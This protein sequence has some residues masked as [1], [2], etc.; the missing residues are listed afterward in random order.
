MRVVEKLYFTVQRI[1]L[2]SL[3][4]QSSPRRGCLRWWEKIGQTLY[5]FCTAKS[6][7]TLLA[8][9]DTERN[10]PLTPRGVPYASHRM[11]WWRCAQGHSWR[12]RIASRTQGAADCPYCK[13]KRVVPGETDLASC[14]PEVAAQWDA[15][16]NGELMP[17][18]LLPS[19]NRVVWWLCEK[20][21]S[22]RAT[23]AHRTREGSACPYCAG[24]RVLPGFNDLAALFP[25]V[26]GQWHPT[27]N[28]ALTP[29]EVTAR[30]HRLIW[31][32]CGE[33]HVW[34]AKIYSRTDVR[35]CG[36]PICA[37]Q[38]RSKLVTQ[39]RGNG[40]Q[41]NLSGGKYK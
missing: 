38:A 30:S 1:L 18:S 11:A 14:F 24:R 26:A 19:S 3:L 9:W 41:Y 7:S 10:A 16:R 28:G 27:L 36:C 20:N 34:K 2:R 37:R 25:K 35:Q 5:D 4:R 23:V 6:M 29:T 12:A 8:Q 21:H 32:Q 17:Q 39:V 31:W 40:Q 33:G 15:A 13:G 22:Y